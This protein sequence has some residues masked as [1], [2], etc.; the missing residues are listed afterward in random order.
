MNPQ[1]FHNLPFKIDIVNENGR[2]F[3]YFLPNYSYK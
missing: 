2:K 1:P 3:Y